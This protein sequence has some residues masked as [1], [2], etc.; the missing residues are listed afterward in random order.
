MKILRV[1]SVALALLLLAACVPTVDYPEDP[2]T[3]VQTTQA[4]TET[5]PE[6]APTPGGLIDFTML[7]RLFSMTLAD[8]WEEEGE[9]VLPESGIHGMPAF[10]FSNYPSATFLIHYVPHAGFDPQ[11]HRPTS[12]FLPLS[13]VLLDE[14]ESLTLGELRQWVSENDIEYFYVVFCDYVEEMLALLRAGAY[15]FRVRLSGNQDDDAVGFFQASTLQ[16]N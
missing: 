11:M 4:Q 14:K 1:V 13:T 15:Y 5:L 2:T 8:F 6:P 3:Q 16:I 12:I 9:Q 10:Q 7:D